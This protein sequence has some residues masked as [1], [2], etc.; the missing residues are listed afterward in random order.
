MAANPQLTDGIY[1]IDVD[2]EGPNAAID[3]Y[4]D[5]TTDGGGWTLIVAQ[6]ESNPTS[7][8]NEGIQG[9]YDPTLGSSKSFALSTSELPSHTQTSFGKGLD[10]TFITYGDFVYTTGNIMKQTINGYDANDYHI[11]R[12]SGIAYGGHDPESSFSGGFEWQDTLTFDLVGGAVTWAFSRRQSA[13][14]S[15]YSMNGSLLQSTS[16]TYAWTVWVR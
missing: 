1:L 9:D 14:I 5:M 12:D 8:W 6:F 10:P 4:C 7:S 13:N 11:H 16:E 15:G 3:V 2:G